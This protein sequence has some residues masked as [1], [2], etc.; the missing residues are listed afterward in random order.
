MNKSLQWCWQWVGHEIHFG[1]QARDWWSQYRLN[2]RATRYFLTIY[3]IAN[4]F[5]KIDI[6]IFDFIAITLENIAP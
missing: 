4:A 6:L 2:L 5:T 3:F 1:M